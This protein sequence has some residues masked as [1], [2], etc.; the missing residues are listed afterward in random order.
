MGGRGASSGISDKGKKYGTEFSTLL[1]VG[2]IKFVK[3]NESSNAKDPLETMT[4][5]RVYVTINDK[6]EI[7]FINYYDSSGKRVKS[8]NLLHDHKEIKGEHTHLGYYHDENGT[9]HLTVQ[10][11][12]LVELVKKK[13]YNRKSK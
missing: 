13:W 4:K 12:K 10:E 1:K 9:R 3:Y 2:N 8:I 5:G 7:N 6:N 11:K